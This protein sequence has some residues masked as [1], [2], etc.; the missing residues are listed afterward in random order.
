MKPSSIY[1]HKLKNGF[2]DKE[3]HPFDSLYSYDS[4]GCKY[5]GD[6]VI[7]L[8]IRL[9]ECSYHNKQFNESK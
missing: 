1:L 5:Y 2:K 6:N 3:I 8:K 7:A 4:C 9:E